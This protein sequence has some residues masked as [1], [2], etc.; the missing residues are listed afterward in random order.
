[1]NLLQMAV[2]NVRVDLG[3]IDGRV[4]EKLLHG[5]D[6]SAISEEICGENVTEGVRRDDIRDASAR[7]I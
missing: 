7:D 1:M 6:V 2:G 5:A 4:A 3:R